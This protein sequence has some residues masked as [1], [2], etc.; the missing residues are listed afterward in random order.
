M[1]QLWTARTA[2]PWLHPVKDVRGDE[3][4][5]AYNCSN[6]KKNQRA[7][8][9]GWKS[10]SGR[11]RQSS[12]GI[13]GCKRP[14]SKTGILMTATWRRSDVH[15]ADSDG[16]PQSAADLPFRQQRSVTTTRTNLSAAA[17]G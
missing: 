9:L 4:R 1:Q 17:V 3:G 12:H 8:V 10:A 7:H 5:T 14:K 2:I 15:G 13:V 6:T 11:L 16:R